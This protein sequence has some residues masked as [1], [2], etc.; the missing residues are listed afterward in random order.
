MTELKRVQEQAKKELTGQ[1]IKKEI[2]EELAKNNRRQ[3][4][5]LARNYILNKY[6]IKTLENDDKPEKYYYHKGVWIPN[7]ESLIQKECNLLFGKALTTHIVNE[8]ILKIKTQTF[9]REKE[10]FKE[11]PKNL[12][13][14]NNGVFDINTEKLLPHN[15]KYNFHNKII[16]DYNLEADCIKIRLFLRQILQE[17]DIKVMQELIGYCL[18]RDHRIHKLFIFEG[19]GRNGKSR[20]L[21]LIKRLIG[22]ENTVSIGLQTLIEKDFAPAELHKKLVNIAG[23]VGD[24]PIYSTD[25]IKGIIGEDQISPDRKF[26]SRISFVPYAKQIYALNNI[27]IVKDTSI[28]WWSKIIPIEFPN[29][30]LNKKEYDKQK[31]DSENV[32]E[33]NPRIVEEISTEQELSG[34]I[35]WGL[36]GLKRLFEKR[37]F[38]EHKS[39][40][41]VKE[42]W[43]NKS[44]NVK[45]FIEKYTTEDYNEYITK[46]EFKRLYVSWCKREKKKQL[47]DTKIKEYMLNNGYYQDRLNDDKKTHV[48]EGLKFKETNPDSKYS[49][50]SLNSPLEDFQKT[51]KGNNN[52]SF[53]YSK[54]ESDDNDLEIVE[55]NLQDVEGF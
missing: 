11:P 10:F 9:Q 16:S 38:S 49:K 48:W 1:D 21:E 31:K 53:K 5:T 23:D 3:A 17:R 41:E 6:R 42:F 13:C 29:T 12:I 33:A 19:E 36:I 45:V 27:P 14:F 44:Y 20:I 2:L 35:N 22:A 55:E 30:F 51:L 34:L 50:Y 28:G 54:S 40:S 43:D 15:H 32:R 46:K 18:V 39:I 8:V 26:L 52:E 47:T 24:K 7:A 4:T 37:E 25:Q